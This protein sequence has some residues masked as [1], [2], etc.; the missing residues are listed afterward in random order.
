MIVGSEHE[1]IRRAASEA[2]GEQSGRLG[3]SH[4]ARQ[5]TR[6]QRHTAY[7]DIEGTRV[8]VGNR[9]RCHPRSHTRERGSPDSRRSATDNPGGLS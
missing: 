3:R 5:F 1:S 2:G 4:D 7:G 8:L 9:D 6:E